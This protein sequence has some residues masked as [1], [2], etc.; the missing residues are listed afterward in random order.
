MLNYSTNI[1]LKFKTFVL[2]YFPCQF[3]H[4]SPHVGH[5]SAHPLFFKTACL[6]GS[7]EYRYF[8]RENFGKWINLKVY[9]WIF[10]VI[11]KNFLDFWGWIC[12]K[13]CDSWFYHAQNFLGIRVN[14]TKEYIALQSEKKIQIRLWKKSKQIIILISSRTK[15]KI[16]N[17][18]AEV[19]SSNKWVLC[20][21]NCPCSLKHEW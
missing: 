21:S 2:N 19:A 15:S 14:S 18:H 8:V 6:F 17:M 11:S 9:C 3:A 4:V 20:P 10:Y 12:L 16:V 7:W 5:N 13:T 1:K